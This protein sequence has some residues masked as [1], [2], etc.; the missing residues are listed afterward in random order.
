[1][2]EAV[3]ACPMTRSSP[4]DTGRSQPLPSS[5]AGRP[6][7]SSRGQHLTRA[8]G[9]V[10]RG[11]PRLRRRCLH[12]RI[13]HS[14]VRIPVSCPGKSVRVRRHD[15]GSH[16]RARPTGQYGY[17]VR[18]PPDAHAPARRPGDFRARRPP[19][20]GRH[21]FRDAGSLRHRVPRLLRGGEC[22][23]GGDDPDRRRAAPGHGYPRRPGA[24]RA[25]QRR[26]RRLLARELRPRSG[27]RRGHGLSSACS[28][29]GPWRRPGRSRRSLS[30]AAACSI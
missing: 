10:K 24:R 13:R 19:R 27:P 1:M 23:T 6:R 25:R 29:A 15:K 5:A 9:Q 17:A 2:G 3:G 30:A 21:R 8:S 28:A 14:P 7:Q 18:A 11:P 22:S 20:H 26:L 16:S 4:A 12:Q